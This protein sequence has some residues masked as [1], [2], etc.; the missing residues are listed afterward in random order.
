MND[1]LRSLTLAG[2][3]G[4]GIATGPDRLTTPPSHAAPI[5][6]EGNLV[7]TYSLHTHTTKFSTHS[8]LTLSTLDRGISEQLDIML[9]VD[10]ASG[11]H[12]AYLPRNT[13]PTLLL[14]CSMNTA[15]IT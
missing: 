3:G 5:K 12:L 9:A 1:Q 13:I 4:V 10:M 14:R 7:S 15:F 8:C 6:R 2:V 11:L